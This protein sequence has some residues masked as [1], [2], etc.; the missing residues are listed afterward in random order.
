MP[1][2]RVEVISD[3]KYHVSMELNFVE[4]VALYVIAGS[5]LPATKGTR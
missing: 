3:P 4:M 1:N 2:T 5:I